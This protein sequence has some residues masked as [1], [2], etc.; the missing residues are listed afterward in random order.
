MGRYRP[1]PV[2][3]LQQH[4]DDNYGGGVHILPNGHDSSLAGQLQ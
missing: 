1:G 4:S 2:I 3:R